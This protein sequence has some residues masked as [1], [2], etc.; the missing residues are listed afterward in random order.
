MKMRAGTQIR[1][2]GSII[3]VT[4]W[5]ITLLTILITAL[6]GQVRLSARVALFHQEELEVWA[7]LLSAIN[8]AEMELM[9]EQMPQVP[10]DPTELV[11]ERLYRYN[12]QELQLDYPHADDITV[13][14]YDHGGK[15]N[16]REISRP[17]MRAML[18]KKLGASASRKIDDLMD[19]WSDW[20]DL[21]DDA[22]VNGAEI[23]YYQELETPY[24]PR[25]GKIETVEEILQIRGFAEVLADIDLEAAFTLYGE[26]DLINLNLATVEAMQLLPGLDDELIEQ[27]LIYRQEKD[28]TGNGDIAQ[29]V[30]AENM[31]LLRPWLNT[32]LK[33]NYYTIMVYKKAE[34][35][36]DDLASDEADAAKAVQEDASLTAFAEIVAISTFTDPP[37]V[38]KIMPYQKVPIRMISPSEDEARQ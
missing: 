38:L 29:I 22:S 14:I 36:T 6:A 35:L 33:S 15:I 3:I 25:N 28:F 8:Q 18:E 9:L 20:E 1:Q 11:R 10:K 7:K 5:T 30:P 19:A 2:R 17:R 4:L 12:G 26:R 24:Q 37:K 34:Q 27:I 13:R 21:N 23:D 32:L 16:L 31:A